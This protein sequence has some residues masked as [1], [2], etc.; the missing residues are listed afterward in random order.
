[1]RAI[2]ASS[3]MF[4]SSGLTI[5]YWKQTSYVTKYFRK[6]YSLSTMHLLYL[7]N[8]SA[9]ARFVVVCTGQVVSIKIYKSNFCMEGSEDD[10]TTMRGTREGLFY[11]ETLVAMFILANV[12]RLYY[13][14]L[15]F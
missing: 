12:G 13:K 2:R 1:M 15:F 8:R 14:A 3:L 4:P 7:L 6:A 9:V 5:K 10:F 11:F